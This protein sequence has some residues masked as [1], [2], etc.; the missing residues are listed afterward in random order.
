[1]AD[2]TC[3]RR[4]EFYKD[5]EWFRDVITADRLTIDAAAIC[6]SYEHD[7]HVNICF[8]DENGHGFPDETFF[9]WGTCVKGVSRRQYLECKFHLEAFA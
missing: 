5:G 9:D 3:T 4:I 7:A 1:M 8:H 2:L 6:M